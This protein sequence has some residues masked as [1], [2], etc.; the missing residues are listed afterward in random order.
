MKIGKMSISL[1]LILIANNSLFG[2]VGSFQNNIKE[3]YIPKELLNISSRNNIT[4]ANATVGSAYLFES[5]VKGAI[6]TKK[7]GLVRG[8]ELNYDLS[9]DD[10]LIYRNG[11]TRIL[12]ITEI[13]S[14]WVS[15]SVHV[16]LNLSDITKGAKS[17]MAVLINK[18]SDDIYLVKVSSANLL[19]PNYNPQF[20]TGSKMATWIIKEVFY[21]I[22][23]TE[24]LSLKE[25]EKQSSK[26]FG[27][28]AKNISIYVKQN[29]LKFKN[30]MDWVTIF[31]YYNTLV[32]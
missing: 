22:K 17:G 6:S 31:E 1:V 15:N 26:V 5:Q 27:E 25:A 14:F 30:I 19:P 24:L 3:A 2:Q 11:L 8:F 16:F 18:T 23:N 9:K 13:D 20:N 29:K 28:N 7:Y 12:H 21:I 32:Y 4:D 10:L